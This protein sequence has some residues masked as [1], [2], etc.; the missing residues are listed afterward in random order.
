VH[1]PNAEIAMK[2]SSTLLLALALLA[3]AAHANEAAAKAPAVK[4]SGASAT[5]QSPAALGDQVRAALATRVLPNKT[6]TL[7]APNQGGARPAPSGP[8]ISAQATAPASSSAIPTPAVSTF[9]G[10]A[11]AGQRS[12]NEG[13]AN[14]RSPATMRASGTDLCTTGKRQSPIAI[15]DGATLLGPAEALQFSY[16]P[17]AGSV[18]NTGQTIQVDVE[19][20]NTL[21]V[22]GSRY[23]LVEFYFRTPSEAQINGKHYAMSAHLVHKNEA[24]QLAVVAVLLEQGASNPVVDT[25]WTH[26]PLDTQDRVRVPPE[27]LKLSDLLPTDQRYY[28]YIGSLTTPPCTEGVLWL[29]L[30]S[31]VQIS[32]AQYT[33][34][35]QLFPNNARPL[36]PRNG[37]PVR[38]AQ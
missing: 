33:L 8:A 2:L 13:P 5:P 4:A 38:E 37:R 27:Q 18:V 23:Q 9:A 11:F 10:A 6:L 16:L 12:G 21:V 28:Q 26:L 30:K 14:A 15:A 29:V 1:H 7:S 22:R 24:G 34:F 35:T 36:Q 17:S 31:P 19:G 20:S 3:P 25:V 32:A